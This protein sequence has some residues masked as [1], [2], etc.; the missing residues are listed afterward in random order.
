MLF[1]CQAE[2]LTSCFAFFPTASGSGGQLA[3]AT[4]VRSP[5]LP[6]GLG[7]TRKFRQTRRSVCVGAQGLPP[8][9]SRTPS[10]PAGAPPLLSSPRL[11]L[12][13]VRRRRLSLQERGVSFWRHEGQ[14]PLFFSALHPPGIGGGAGG[15]ENVMKVWGFAR[16]PS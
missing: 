4:V 12:G 9:R 14:L 7:G 10:T 1:S 8:P 11:P 2:S 3:S 6:W 13:C 16:P 5:Q 15:R